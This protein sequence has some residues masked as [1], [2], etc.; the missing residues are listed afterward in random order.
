MPLGAL[1]F[2]S[3]PF[4][5]LNGK[6][7]AIRS[8]LRTDWLAWSALRA[9]SRDFLT[10]WEPSWAVD[11]LSKAAFRRRLMRYAVDW[12]DRMGYSFFIIR[13]A[14]NALLGG[15]T[16]SNIRRGVAETGSIGYW[17]GQPHARQ[18]YMTEALELA[19]SFG[20]E[21]LRLHRIEAAC[22]PANQASRGLLTKA[23]FTQEGYARQYLFINGSWADHV[24]YAM[25]RDDWKGR[26]QK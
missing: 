21:H 20:F 11:S 6:K 19:L 24:L 3:V 15:L 5:N 13:I 10:P 2:S 1:F 23:G 12:R 16:F 26:K 8:P 14:D 25:L 22:L 18:G 17:I 4:V 9:Q 7:I